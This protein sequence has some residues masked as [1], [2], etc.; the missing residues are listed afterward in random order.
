M[1]ELAMVSIMVTSSNSSEYIL[2]TKG[3]YLVVE[4]TIQS[5]HGLR[6]IVNVALCT[7]ESDTALI[8]I[9]TTSYIKWGD[10]NNFNIKIIFKVSQMVNKIFMIYKNQFKIVSN[11]NNGVYKLYILL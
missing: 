6:K 3:I 9:S 10:V 11:S 5:L 7:Q 1:V 2:R 4:A 8:S